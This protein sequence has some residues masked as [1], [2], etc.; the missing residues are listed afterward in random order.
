MTIWTSLRAALLSSCANSWSPHGTLSWSTT[1]LF[2]TLIYVA[3]CF[4]LRFRSLSKVQSRFNFPDRASLSRMTGADAQAIIEHAYTYEFPLFFGLSLTYALTKTFAIQ[5]IAKLLVT[6][7]FGRGSKIR[8]HGANIRVLHGAV[9]RM[10]YLH[11]PYIRSGKIQNGD[12]LYVLYAAM[13]EPVRFIRLYEWRELAQFEV[14]AQGTLWKIVGD[15]MGIDYTKELGRNNFRDGIEFMEEVEK[16]SLHYEVD[17]LRPSLP[18][19]QLANAQLDLL[20]WVFPGFMRPLMRQMGLVMMGDKIRSSFG[21]PEPSTALSALTLTLLWLRQILMRFFMLPRLTNRRYVT[22]PDPRTGRMFS[23]HYV[24][25]PWYNRPTPWKRWGP[26]AWAVWAFGGMLPGDGGAE[27]RP[28]GFLFEDIGPKSKMGLGVEETR[29]IQEM[30]H[31]TAMSS[32]RCPF[33]FKG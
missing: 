20:T 19:R 31:A 25:E 1:C 27:M 30:V 16:W 33:T 29:N 4:L 26:A 22:D 8:R 14:A 32:G 17:R 6:S 13:T 18:S 11:A 9:A 10:N 24:K 3:T 2:I 12:L 7:D 21:F 23:T 28:E 15:M 5:N